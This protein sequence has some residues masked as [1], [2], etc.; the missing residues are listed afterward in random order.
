MKKLIF[1]TFIF[2]LFSITNY[3]QI[4]LDYTNSIEQE[5]NTYMYNTFS[6][7]YYSQIHKSGSNVIWDFSDYTPSNTSISTS[8]YIQNPESQFF[9]NAQQQE[10]I[11]ETQVS[12]FFMYND[13]GVYVTGQ[14]IGDAQL[15]FTN[16]AFLQYP[17]TYESVYSGDFEGTII[18]DSNIFDRIGSYKIE[19]DG[20]GT[21]LLPDKTFNN[22]LRIVTTYTY[23]DYMEYPEYSEPVEVSSGKDSIF[24]WFSLEHPVYVAGY[25]VG[26]SQGVLKY[27]ERFMYISSENADLST[28]LTLG[29]E[30]KSTFLD[31]KQNNNISIANAVSCKIY[32]KNGQKILYIPASE[33]SQDVCLNHLKPGVYYAVLSDNNSR[34]STAIIIQ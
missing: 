16:R 8:T 19:S 4:T 31:I 17:L 5:N 14:L 7:F 9:P 28:N 33:H 22:V 1:S 3:S 26:Y 13:T 21:L 23:S 27:T 20:Y 32:D 2:C 25:S 30:S 12:N 10:L 18:N 29:T 6:T 15:Q 24:L 34:Q 11:E